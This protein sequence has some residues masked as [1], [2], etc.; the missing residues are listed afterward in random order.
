MLH[1]DVGFAVVDRVT[2][3]PALIETLKSGPPADF[4][5]FDVDLPGGGGI[6]ALRELHGLAPAMRIAAFAEH[7]EPREILAVL[8]AGA[9]GFVPKDIG[10]GKDLLGALRTVAAGEI[11]VPASIVSPV[12]ER[13]AGEPP[14]V[15]GKAL[16]S[17]T[18]RQRQVIRLL[19]QGHANKVIAR[20]LGISPSTVKVHV[21][22]AFRA[23]GVHSRLAAVAALHPAP[24]PPVPA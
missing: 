22:A 12:E 14:S 18:A 24:R 4:L 7:A 13:R 9:L 10:I 20:E 5:A 19:S 21:H 8:S 16:A 23:L 15:D 2:D 11:F 6:G 1:R 17:L 3:Y